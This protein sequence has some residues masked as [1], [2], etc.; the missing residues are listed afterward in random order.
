MSLLRIAA[1]RSLR[2][3]QPHHR[4]T[5]ITA[6]TPQWHRAFS[7]TPQIFRKDPIK[8]AP[9]WAP[10][11]ATESEAEVK[12]DREPIPKDLLEFQKETI[13]IIV[14]NDKD[15]A[16]EIKQIADDFFKRLEKLGEKIGVKL[17]VKDKTSR[18]LGEMI[19]KLEVKLKL[20]RVDTSS[21]HHITDD[22]LHRRLEKLEEELS[23][24]LGKDMNG[25]SEVII[26]K[27]AYRAEEAGAA[28]GNVA[29]TVKGRVDRAEDRIED[30]G[31]SVVDGVKAGAHKV[32]NFVK[33]SLDSVKKTVGINGQNTAEKIKKKS[34]DVDDRVDSDRGA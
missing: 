22:D 29:G 30:A 11:N 7:S 15:G 10:E 2:L 1:A 9:G 24:K 26:E 27:L 4:A 21:N 12:A 13:E 5:P 3:V 31:E 23:Q 33:E 34:K 17:E 8:S 20:K 6:A 14:E 18:E 28:L 25:K 32:S 16:S 19:E